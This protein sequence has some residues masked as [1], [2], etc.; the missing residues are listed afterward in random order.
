MHEEGAGRRINSPHVLRVLEP[1]RR[2]QFLY[3]VT[4]YVEGQTLRQWMNDYPLA[5]LPDVR[6]IVEQLARGLRAFQR[7]EMIHQDLKPE[8]ILID[9]HGT[10][11][12]ID[13]G[14]TR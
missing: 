2:R 6:N 1:T 9:K 7:M 11:K 12:I 10:V 5:A 4:E 14:S 8:N 3:Y 13:F